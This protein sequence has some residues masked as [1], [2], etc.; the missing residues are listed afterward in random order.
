MTAKRKLQIIT[1]AIMTALL[2]MLMAYSLIGEEFHEWAGIAMFILFLLHHGL[3]WK[4]HTN[5]F[6]GRYRTVRA[7]GTAVN[8]LIF[9]MMLTLMISG[10]VMSRYAFSFL[11]AGGGQSLARSAHMVVSYWCYVL[12][13]VHLGFHGVGILGMLRKVFRR[14][15]ASK[16]RTNIIRIVAA[17][18]AAYGI[19]AFIKRDFVDYMLMRTHFAF[20][21]FSEPLIYFLAD[22]FAVMALFALLGY[23]AVKLLSV[24]GRRGQD[25][26]R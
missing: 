14:E 25:K 20:Y 18:T 21:D 11:A 22:Y 15:K 5:L 19:C 12:V 3:N 16:A 13:S 17:V 2:P 6:R 26:D 4:W 8:I 24:F 23:Y 7:L 1:D 10:M 9:L